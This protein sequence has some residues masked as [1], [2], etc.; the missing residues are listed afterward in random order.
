MQERE[1]E[2]PSSRWE[3]AVL[4]NIQISLWN[5]SNS[6]KFIEVNIVRVFLPAIL[7]IISNGWSAEK[8]ETAYFRQE[9]TPVRSISHMKIKHDLD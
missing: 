9:M 1:N 3:I 2:A 6:T 4:G 5:S 7:D 8:V